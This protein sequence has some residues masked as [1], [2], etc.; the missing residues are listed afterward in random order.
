MRCLGGGGA[1]EAAGQTR[2][3]ADVLAAL[4]G[5]ELLDTRGG[6]VPFAS[7]SAGAS[8]PVVVVWVRNFA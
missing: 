8:G 3:D 4:Q 6:R 5:V 7:L 1:R 2:S